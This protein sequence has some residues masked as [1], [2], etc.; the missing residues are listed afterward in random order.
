MNRYH[1]QD[2]AAGFYALTVYGDNKQ[3]ALNRY[4]AQWYP[5]RARLPKGITIWED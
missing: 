1:L 4:R 3:D 5:D 2:P